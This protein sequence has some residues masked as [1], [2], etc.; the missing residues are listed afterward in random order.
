MGSGQ[1]A[2][3][4]GTAGGKASR[5]RQI[6]RVHFKA[7]HDAPSRRYLL[8]LVRQYPALFSSHSRLL[9][10]HIVPDQRYSS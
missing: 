3:G 4:Q 8:C 1:G 6:G 2:A 9:A 7:L 10:A 5:D